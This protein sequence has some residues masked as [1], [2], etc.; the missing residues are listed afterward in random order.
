[1]TSIRKGFPLWYNQTQTIGFD[2]ASIV[3][4]EC[5]K[6]SDYVPPT[7]PDVKENHCLVLV[8][9]GAGNRL[10]GVAFCNANAFEMYSGAVLECDFKQ[11]LYEAPREFIET[12]RA[13]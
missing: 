3:V 11:E 5:R 1:M 4:R 13:K 7:P 12:H 6:I 10:L 9:K 2:D 8:V